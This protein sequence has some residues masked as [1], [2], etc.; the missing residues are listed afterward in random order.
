MNITNKT[1]FFVY[2]SITIAVLAG[3]V[4]HEALAEDLDGLWKAVPEFAP[5]FDESA[6][7]VQIHT[8]II[9]IRDSG[10]PLITGIDLDK[11]F[12]RYIDDY[13]R[14]ERG[15]MGP[16]VSGMT[17]RWRVKPLPDDP[18]TKYF[19]GSKRKEPYYRRFV[20]LEIGVF[21]S[22][23]QALLAARYRLTHQQAHVPMDALDPGDPGFVSWGGTFFVRDNVFYSLQVSPEFNPASV[24]KQFHDD[25]IHG[26][27]GITKGDKVPLP[28]IQGDN[29]PSDMTS[30]KMEGNLAAPLDVKDPNGRPLYCAVWVADHDLDAARRG[31]SWEELSRLN[32]P[33]TKSPTIRW[34]KPNIVVVEKVGNVT[35]VDLAAVAMNDLC[36]VSDIWTKRVR[37]AP[38]REEPGKE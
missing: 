2:F 9:P 37:I 8:G 13:D 22:H 17:W 35:V 19:W 7:S 15:A 23:G 30:F 20:K 18:D 21:S 6:D 26:A 11:V 12:S 4:W 24:L 10:R 5:K 36:V 32:I 38:P 28:I 27:E 34:V 25:L 31:L 1:L 3:F 14:F 29:F 33:S 16:D